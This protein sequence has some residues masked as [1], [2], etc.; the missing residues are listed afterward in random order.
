[1]RAFGMN[2]RLVGAPFVLTIT[3]AVV[4]GFVGGALSPRVF[5][6]EPALAR[7][8]S[9]T[10]T[11]ERF[12]LQDAAGKIRAELG[13]FD[14]DGA[15]VF[16]MLDEQGT[17]RLE[18]GFGERQFRIPVLR[19]FDQDGRPRIRIGAG[20]GGGAFVHL[21]DA[22]FTRRAALGIRPNGN[23]ELLLGEPGTDVTLAGFRVKVSVDADGTPHLVL[24]DM[25]LP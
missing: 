19:V 8:S 24:A 20:T 7:S 17:P 15:P 25:E 3:L 23:V 11:A 10:I 4:A 5:S 9:N 6:D 13:L 1:M 16:R 2:G 21:H 14:D 18:M 22:D 12:V